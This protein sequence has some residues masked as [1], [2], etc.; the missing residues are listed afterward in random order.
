MKAIYVT[1]TNEPEATELCIL[2]LW[3]KKNYYR[4]NAENSY[5]PW[6][7]TSWKNSLIEAGHTAILM[8]ESHGPKEQLIGNTKMLNRIINRILNETLWLFILSIEG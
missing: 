4:T 1:K 6:T 8:D 7:S 5:G 2:I 3:K